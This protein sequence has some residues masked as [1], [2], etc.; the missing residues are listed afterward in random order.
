[1]I[2]LFSKNIRII[3]LYLIA[4]VTLGMIIGGT[5]ASIRNISELILPDREID[6][7]TAYKDVTNTGI[8]GRIDTTAQINATKIRNI[9]NVIYSVIVVGVGAPLFMFNWKQIEKERTNEKEVK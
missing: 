4:L 1:V 7:S 2:L 3:Y 5:V 6:Y 9:K 8:N